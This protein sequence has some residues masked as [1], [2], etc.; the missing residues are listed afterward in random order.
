MTATLS[1]LFRPNLHN[2]D[3]KLQHQQI[4]KGQTGEYAIIKEAKVCVRYLQSV[5]DDGIWNIRYKD[6][7]KNTTQANSFLVSQ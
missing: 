2:G 5:N 7:H 1:S 6:I 3:P 4:S